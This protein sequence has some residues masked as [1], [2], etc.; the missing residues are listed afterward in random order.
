MRTPAEYQAAWDRA[1]AEYAKTGRRPQPQTQQ[2][3]AVR[4]AEVPVA[5]KAAA[6][7]ALASDVWPAEVSVTLRRL[8]H[9]EKVSAAVV[10]RTLEHCASLPE[11]SAWAHLAAA[12]LPA[13]A[14]SS[15]VKSAPSDVADGIMICLR[16]DDA[17][18]ARLAITDGTPAADLHVTLAYLGKVGEDGNDQARYEDVEQV[19][20]QYA[21]IAAPL[22]GE[23]AGIGEFTASGTENGGV[24]LIALV[25]VPGLNGWR[26]ALMRNLARLDVPVAENHGY[27]PHMTL[28]YDMPVSD[29]PESVPG[30]A[31]AFDAVWLVWGAEWLRYPLDG[32]FTGLLS[33]TGAEEKAAGVRRVRT[34][35]GSRLYDLP[36]GAIIVRDPSKPAP[37]IDP[38]A[39][40]AP[41]VDP[42][43]KQPTPA[44]KTGDTEK[45]K[46]LVKSVEQRIA[47]GVDPKEAATAYKKELHATRLRIQRARRK[48]EELAAKA[49]AED[50]TLD[51]GHTTKD[52]SSDDI[53][54]AAGTGELLD[55]MSKP[56]E[57]AKALYGAAAFNDWVGEPAT[58]EGNYTN[59]QI[60]KFIA[61]K[62]PGFV[63]KGTL[64]YD[65]LQHDTELDEYLPVMNVRVGGPTIESSH[66]IKT[67][68][69][70]RRSGITYVIESADAADDGTPSAD[71]KT[72]LANTISMYQKVLSGIPED[73]R[74][75]QR[76]VALLAAPN[77]LDAFWAQKYGIDNFQ[78]FATGGYGG[79]HFWNGNDPSPTTVAHE[80]G[81]NLDTATTGG[82]STSTGPVLEG[83]PMSWSSAADVDMLTSDYFAAKIDA[84]PGWFTATRVA[85][86]THPIT[87]GKKGVSDYGNAH[88]NEDFAESVRLYLKDRREGKL[89]FLKP[90]AGQST[91]TNIRFADV[92]PERSRILDAAFGTKTEYATAFNT[93]QRDALRRKFEAND[94][95]D[96][97]YAQQLG[98]D[99]GLSESDVTDVFVS[100]KQ[101]KYKKIQYDALLNDTETAMQMGIL[102]GSAGTDAEKAVLLV[103]FGGGEN[104]LLTD[105]DHVAIFDAAA[106][107]Y[108]AWK[109]ANDQMKLDILEKHLAAAKADPGAYVGALGFHNAG[110]YADAAQLSG[111]EQADLAA[112]VKDAAVGF[113]FASVQKFVPFALGTGVDEPDD[114]KLLASITDVYASNGLLKQF[115]VSDEQIAF[116]AHQSFNEIK[117][118]KQ[119]D[120]ADAVAEEAAAS[121]EKMSLEAAQAQAALM[122]INDL[123]KELGQKIRKRKAFVKYKAKQSQ[124]VTTTAAE[125]WKEESPSGP[126]TFNVG[127]DHPTEYFITKLN[128]AYA[129]KTVT[130][131][132]APGVM[133][134]AS[135]PKSA[136]VVDHFEAG[137]YGSGSPIFFAVYTADAA[138]TQY[139]VP[140]NRIGSITTDGPGLSEADAQKLADEYEAK[141]VTEALVAQLLGNDV[142]VTGGAVEANDPGK[143]RLFKEAT[144]RKGNVWLKQAGVNPDDAAASHTIPGIKLSYH[145]SE[146]AKQNLAANIA[147]R[148]DTP[149]VWEI[150]REFSKSYG[151]GSG[152]T[153]GRSKS[154][155]KPYDEYSTGERLALLYGEVAYRVRRWAGTS[156]DSAVGPLMMQKAAQE[157]FGLD[158]DY[159]ARLVHSDSAYDQKNKDKIIEGVEKVYAER[160]G[161]WFR[162]LLRAM[163]D[164]TQASF[165]EAGITHVSL[166]R[167]MGIPKDQ[168]W[169]IGDVVERVRLQPINSWSSSKKTANAFK[170]GYGRLLVTEVPVERIVGSART[171]FGCL[172]ESEFVVMDTPGPVRIDG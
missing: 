165:K 134:P 75:L 37:V 10:R 141:A 60:D 28:G 163:Y 73:K 61:G 155:L 53:F 154:E 137:Q 26:E 169:P 99:F 146:R 97:I 36:I 30:T 121:A 143:L 82:I 15:N 105:A 172:N 101:E 68:W 86:G 14:T 140:M 145:A 54:L 120:A 147:T 112:Q 128:D 106:E 162:T 166:Y 95:G 91:G 157:E 85:P 167:G 19:V 58:A 144:R 79:T 6:R 17:T 170:K 168:T 9:Q 93:Q 133:K 160:T 44:D 31:L 78:S 27:T 18:A 132:P 164:N 124:K 64:F 49:A 90:T 92:W 80:F 1:R 55:F 47:E 51:A 21:Q 67:G 3:R 34:V 109:A 83:Q 108:A 23:V 59:E 149:E 88:V 110:F 46:A 16:P 94:P 111:A 12:G 129:G 24:P 153:G 151:I 126:L 131:K 77:P 63:P 48:Q 41:Y 122:D 102:P 5:V 135:L 119:A 89:G 139:R 22:S 4:M 52:V 38:R 125:F 100:F 39:L 62:G 2:R 33:E 43:G 8:A 13:S 152:H 96:S 161:V 20:R 114:D 66:E 142:T 138:G 40:P 104:K 98:H 117:A 136:F 42:A 65:A 71:V 103:D 57:K 45:A 69:A 115:G 74:G 32:D 107:K 87:F 84:D 50:Q 70:V 159:K 7:N 156:G 11:L 25:D 118:E 35:E 171:G 81:H 116:H 29:V 76:G 158:S 113:A 123:P 56:G 72:R 148:L 127:G 150:F 130:M